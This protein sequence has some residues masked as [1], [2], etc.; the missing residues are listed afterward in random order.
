MVIEEQLKVHHSSFPNTTI[1]VSY[2]SEAACFR[3]LQSDSTRMIIVAK[4]LNDTEATFFEN[5]LSFKP[6]YGILA[7][8]AVVVIVNKESK[9][10]VFTI[11][12]LKDIL[13]GKNKK[14]AVM[15]GKNATSTVRYLQDSVLRGLPLG[16]NVVAAEGSEK[17]IEVV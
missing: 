2:K 16:S 5:K 1:Q 17:V 11:A 6:Q 4:G 15:D 12:Q 14:M 8:D 9:D 3:D 13:N 7:Y 10:S